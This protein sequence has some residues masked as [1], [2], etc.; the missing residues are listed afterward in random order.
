MRLDRPGRAHCAGAR[1][2]LWLWVLALAAALP[3]AACGRGG[4]APTAEA[5]LRQDQTEL[6]LKTLADA[7]SQGFSPA[8][9]PTAGLAEDL[10]SDDGGKRAAAQARLSG[11]IIAYARAQH[12]LGLA[13]SQMDPNWGMRPAKYDARDEFHAALAQNRLQAWLDSL[14]PPD[15][16]YQVLRQGYLTYLKLAQ[17]GGW[18]PVPAGPPMRLGSRDLRVQALRQRLAFEDAAIAQAAGDQDR[19]ARPFDAALAQAVARF[20]DRHGLKP[21]GVVD[22]KTLAALNVP[23]IARAAQIRANLER[24]RWAPRNPSPT[25]V[26][27]N[28]VA[29]TFDLW[30]DGQPAMHM[31]AAAGKPGDETPIVASAIHTV[32]LNPTWNVPDSIAHDE[33]YPKEQANPGY[34]AAHHF[35][36]E[37]GRLVQQPGPDNALGRVK[38]L[39]DNPYS[40]YL[41]DTP[42]KAAFD[43][44]QRSVSHGCVRL[45]Q[46]IDL[47]KFLLGRE[48]GW[49]PEK[50]DEA[51]SSTDTHNV[52][53]PHP[54]PVEIFYWTAFVQG[55]QVSFRDDI[56]GWDQELLRQLD[57]SPSSHA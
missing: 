36:T 22:D 39:F 35:T 21:T 32:V 57:A 14:P 2:G 6:I 48:L 5:P 43:Q 1:A 45:Q 54:V 30:W 49:P 46:A 11:E 38:F 10:K 24:W 34:F 41:H 3:L 33:L 47:A 12:G 20:Q 26:E 37:G 40:I 29:G 23:A 8:R 31:L 16:R 42:A 50:V 7:P 15:P 17:Q 28:S 19:A 52:S 51:L 18:Q 53:L 4:P 13:K 27:V 9:F 25:R 56:Y 55:D 44:A